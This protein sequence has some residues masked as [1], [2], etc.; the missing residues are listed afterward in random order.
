MKKIILSSCIFILLLSG[1]SKKSSEFSKLKSESSANKSVININKEFAE[2][3]IS[4]GKKYAPTYKSKGI[5]SKI[6]FDFTKM[7][8]N[9]ALSLIYDIMVEPENYLNK[10]IKIEGQYDTIVEDDIRYFAVIDW[11]LTGCCPAGLNFIP[12]DSMKFP[13]DFPELETTITV[14][15]RIEKTFNGVSEEFY[16]MA[17]NIIS[18]SK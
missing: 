17:D 1:C 10:T 9:M 12:P 4:E 7:N 16:F 3:K 8:F 2:S 15:G 18:D 11:D 13:E 5:P 14:T 6:D